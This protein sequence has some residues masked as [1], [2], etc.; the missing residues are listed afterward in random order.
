MSRFC[1]ASREAFSSSSA[2][3]RWSS[4]CWTCNS[5]D[6]AWSSAVSRWDSSSSSSVRT[7]ATMVLRLTP[8]VGISCARKSWWIWVK[9]VTDASSITPRTCSS[10]TMGSTTSAVG[11]VCP[12][13]EEMVT[14]PAG[15]SSTVTLR[16]LRAACPTSERPTGIRVGRSSSS[17]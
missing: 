9:R 12:R 8:I 6:R 4:S 2:L 5:S 3:E 15:S 17:G 11:R 14:Y 16:R 7:L 13:P 10:T 1:D